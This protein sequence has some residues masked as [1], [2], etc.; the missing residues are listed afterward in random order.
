[1]GYAGPW[2]DVPQCQRCSI[3]GLL[4]VILFW[5]WS[6]V[7]LVVYIQDIWRVGFID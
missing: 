1:M 7:D 6:W 5:F 4:G 3:K 2:V